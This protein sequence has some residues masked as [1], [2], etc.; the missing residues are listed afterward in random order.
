[1]RLVCPNCG[2]QYEVPAEVISSEGRDVQC[3][4]CG[5]TWYQPSPDAESA[6]EDLA[7][8]YE[9]EDEGF[10]PAEEAEEEAERDALDEPSPPPAAGFEERFE[11]E[12]ENAFDTSSEAEMGED[13]Y[14]YEEDLAEAPP[15]DPALAAAITGRAARSDDRDAAEDAE[16]HA[17]DAEEEPEAADHLDEA[18]ALDADFPEDGYP[19]VDA[20]AAATEPEDEVETPPAR[21]VPRRPLSPDVQ[22]VLQAEAAYEAKARARSADPLESQPDLGLGE[23][24]TPAQRRERET[25]ERLNRLRGM[26]AMTASRTATPDPQPAPP[27]PP[28]EPEAAAPQPVPGEPVTAPGAAPRRDLL[29]DIEEINSSLGSKGLKRPAPAAEAPEV[30]T[31]AQRRGFRLGFGLMLLL[32]A[33]LILYYMHAGW[34]SDTFP[35]LA[36]TTDAYVEVAD[37]FRVWLD[38]RAS[39]L[40]AWMEGMS[41]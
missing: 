17:L 21:V 3:S 4:N 19:E 31:R 39:Q 12:D 24:E 6:G 16:A 28:S 38:A 33:A 27:A 37:M 8:A 5:I 29:P 40:H 14:D 2:A 25:R 36:D 22:S 35:A 34:V 41:D 11:N 7:D 1:M 20:P 26:T 32:G 10:A 30:D 18:D 15:P 23:P 13:D 9:D